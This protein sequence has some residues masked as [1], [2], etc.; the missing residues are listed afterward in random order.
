MLESSEGRSSPAIRSTT[1][2]N[3]FGVCMSSGQPHLT[4]GSHSLAIQGVENRATDA[5]DT[6]RVDVKLTDT[7][8]AIRSLV[9]LFSPVIG[10]LGL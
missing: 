1:L 6:Y 5:R 2:L 3:L 8:I 7:E 4:G 9:V 10:F